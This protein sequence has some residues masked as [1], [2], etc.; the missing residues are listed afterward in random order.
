M[1]PDILFIRNIQKELG[2]IMYELRVKEGYTINGLAK[3][4]GISP[5]SISFKESGK[6]NISVND[7]LLYASFFG[8]FPS[9]LLSL[10]EQRA[11]SR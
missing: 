2:I 10:A 4:L 1:N 5:P 3:A 11:M 8:L 7:I 6:R 9:D